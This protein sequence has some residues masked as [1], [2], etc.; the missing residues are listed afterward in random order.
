MPETSKGSDL[1]KQLREQGFSKWRIGKELSVSWQTVNF[2]S[3]D[4]FQPTPEHYEVLRKLI[5][6]DKP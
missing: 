1:I 5:H 3:K 6:E 2:W 4:V